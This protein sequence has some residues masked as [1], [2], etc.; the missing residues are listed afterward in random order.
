MKTSIRV[1]SIINIPIEIDISWIIIFALI[2]VSF[3]EGYFPSIEKNISVANRWIFGIIATVLFFTSILLHELAHSYV[4][5][6]NNI[7]IKKITLFIFGGIASIT[8][9][10]EDPGTE[11]KIAIAG[12]LLSIA[13]GFIFYGLAKTVSQL[14]PHYI[15]LG[16]LFGYL[17]L[18][19]FIL[20]GFNLVPAFPL[21]GGRVFRAFMWMIT[22]NMEKATRIASYLGQAFAFFLIFIG[23]MQILS[24]HSLLGG[25]WLILI[26]IFLNNAATTSWQNVVFRNFIGGNRVKDLMTTEVVTIHPGATIEDLIQNYFLHYKHIVIPVVD[27]KQALGIITLHEAKA[28]PKEERTTTLVQN[29]MKKLDNTMQIAPSGTIVEA[30]NRIQKEGLGGLLVIE[31]AKLLGIL[32]KS[33]ILKFMQIK[34][35]LE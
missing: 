20:A 29:V 3:S 15:T 34:M 13:L 4:A 16:N 1:G 19:N 7:K 25:I 27:H 9:E 35:Q 17:S 22:K 10:P 6:K 14:M 31:D 32:T 26:G 23:I 24:K 21:D 11:F 8:K 5:Q 2:A 18:I 12:P 33:D 30:L 28:V